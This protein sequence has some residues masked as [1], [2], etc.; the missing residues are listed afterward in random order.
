MTSKVKLDGWSMTKS[1]TALVVGR[2]VTLGKLDIDRPIASLY[3]EA[4]RAHG[5]LTPRH[6]LTMTSGP[7]PQL[8]A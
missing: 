6:L 4:D 5:A 1:V 3:P 2:A 8:A 7:A